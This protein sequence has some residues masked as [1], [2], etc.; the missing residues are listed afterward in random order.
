[1]LKSNVFIISYEKFFPLLS[2]FTVLVALIK[3]SS[4]DR[5]SCKTV[6]LKANSQITR[7]D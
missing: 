1:M 3:L 7:E 5:T 6:L 2:N 4:H